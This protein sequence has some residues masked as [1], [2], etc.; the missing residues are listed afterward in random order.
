VNLHYEVELAL[1]MG[2]DLKDLEASD[3]QTAYDAIESY[4]V[5]IDMTARNMQDEAKKKGLP[6][7]IAKGFDTFLPLSHIIPKEKIPDPHNAELWLT[8]NNE[9]QQRDNTNLM[10]FRIPRILSDISKVMRIQKGDIILTGT[11]KGVGRVVPGDI[12]KAGILVDG[13][14]IK[15][16]D[17]E[18]LV[19]ESTSTFEYKET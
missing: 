1:I 9:H 10:L 18:V 8:V 2:K 5:G 3:E 13:K 12:M 19:A 6:W 7:S 11:P 17:I 4:A 15:E 16:G 14:E